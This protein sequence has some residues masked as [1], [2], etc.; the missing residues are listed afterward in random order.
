MNR[1]RLKVISISLY[2]IV[3]PC[4][5]AYLSLIDLGVLS[6]SLL[7]FSLLTLVII[8]LSTA[9]I[10]GK[11]KNSNYEFEVNKMYEKIMCI[12]VLCEF[13]YSFSK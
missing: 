3:C 7:I 5:L 8:A 13:A 1:N 4:L 2:Y 10:I 11:K 6:G 9:V 12:L